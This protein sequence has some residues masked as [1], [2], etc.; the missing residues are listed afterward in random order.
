MTALVKLPSIDR[1]AL[2]ARSPCPEAP[3]SNKYNAITYNPA[4]WGLEYLSYRYLENLD[5][6]ALRASYDSILRMGRA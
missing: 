4:L 5:E 3:A 6:D 2:P 1:L